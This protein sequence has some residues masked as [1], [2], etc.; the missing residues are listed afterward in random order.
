ESSANV[1]NTSRWTATTRSFVPVASAEYGIPAGH[2]R[3]TV[4]TGNAVK[5]TYYDG[6]WRPLL[7]REYD[8]ANAAG[9]Q[10]FARTEYDAEG[11][12]TFQSYPS[13]ASSPT[14]GLWTEYDA[15]GRV[16]SVSQDSELGLLTTT[17]EYLSGGRIRVTNPRGF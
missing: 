16:T 2:W 5:V 17:T 7:V 9:T 1:C 3:E 14:A 12:V 4:T 15:L 8:S 6:L 13:T 10:R 11:R